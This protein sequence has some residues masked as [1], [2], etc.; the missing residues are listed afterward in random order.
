MHLSRTCL[1]GFGLGS[2][3]DSTKE[4][5]T[6]LSHVAGIDLPSS[7]VTRFSG[8]AQHLQINTDLGTPAL[9]RR[10][11]RLNAEVR[12]LSEDRASLRSA[13]SQQG[14]HLPGTR[15]VHV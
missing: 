9:L 1:A 10:I 12:G 11:A 6:P 13:V 8:F 15:G 14:L 5:L 3:L 7:F 2:L 4:A